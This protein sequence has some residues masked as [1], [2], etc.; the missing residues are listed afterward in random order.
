MKNLFSGNVD[1]DGFGTLKVEVME[2]YINGSGA[3][4]GISLKGECVNSETGFKSV[5]GLYQEDYVNF[6]VDAFINEFVSSG[7][8]TTPLPSTPLPSTTCSSIFEKKEDHVFDDDF[9]MSI[10][11]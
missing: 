7:L 10:V 11:F 2:W 6:D 1:I 9:Q 8:H 5:Q 3:L 4:I